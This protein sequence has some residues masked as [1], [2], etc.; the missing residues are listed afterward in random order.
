M[1]PV[2]VPLCVVLLVLLLLG[3]DYARDRGWFASHYSIAGELVVITGAGGGLGRELALHCAKRGAVL[4]LWDVR[5]EALVEVVAW[6]ETHGV[7]RGCIHERVVDVSDAAAVE[8]AGKAQSASLGPARIVIINA[9]V[10]TGARILDANEAQL[11]NAIGVNLLAHV[12]CVRTFLPQMIAPPRPHGTI[13]TLGS[14]MAAIPAAGLA[15]YC[16]CKAAIAQLHECLRW[17]LGSLG[18]AAAG[19][20]HLMHVQP[21]LIDTPLFAGGQP[22]RYAWLRALLPPLQATSVARR[23]IDGVQTRREH[24]V[25]PWVLKWLPS[26]LAMLPVLLR[27]TALD[28]AGAGCAMDTFTGRGPQRKGGRRSRSPR[29]AKRH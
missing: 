17:E 15:D 4:A 1:F 26:L 24:L 2:F 5:Q 18:A 7:A 9:A 11:V 27:D 21:Y 22:L 25:L 6:L 20:V 14:L 8:R 12:W 13:V 23:I 10:V 16:A 29:A 3:F 28:L 19:N